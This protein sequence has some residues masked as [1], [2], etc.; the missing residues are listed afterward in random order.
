MT[1]A[2]VDVVAPIPQALRLGWHGFGL[3]SFIV[4]LAIILLFVNYPTTFS[5][6]FSASARLPMVA[7]WDHL[8]P[9]WFTRL[10]SRYKTPVNSVI[11]LGLVT[12]AGSA[13]APIGVGPQEA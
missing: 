7:G 2:A 3:A 1:P 9:E 12:L 11:F 10:H 6:Y 13:V 4:P 8:L 5:V